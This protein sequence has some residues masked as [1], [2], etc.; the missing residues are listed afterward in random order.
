MINSNECEEIFEF[1]SYMNKVEVMKIPIEI[2]NFIKNN[3]NE[4]FNT[5]IDKDD[6]FN[7][8]NLS[9]NSLNFLLYIDEVYWKNNKNSIQSNNTTVFEKAKENKT[10]LLVIEN[11]KPIQKIFEKIREWFKRI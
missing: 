1:L 5:K 2:L 8:D 7:L 6:L 4:L 11:K 3:R 9:E 10:E